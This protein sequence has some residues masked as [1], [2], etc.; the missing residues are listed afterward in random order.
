MIVS[1]IL[2]QKGKKQLF[3]TRHEAE[4]DTVENEIKILS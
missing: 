1:E 4:V 2:I 3:L